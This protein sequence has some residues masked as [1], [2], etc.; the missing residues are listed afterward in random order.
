MRP[1]A[2]VGMVMVIIWVWETVTEMVVQESIF[3]AF[4]YELVDFIL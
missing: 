1:I 2:A 4:E 3:K